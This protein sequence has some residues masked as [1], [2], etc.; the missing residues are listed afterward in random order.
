MTDER[1]RVNAPLVGGGRTKKLGPD[2][3]GQG[4]F[5]QLLTAYWRQPRSQWQWPCGPQPPCTWMTWPVALDAPE[6]GAAGMAWAPKVVNA[7]KAAIAANKANSLR[8]LF[9]PDVS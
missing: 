2:K 8:M 6:S 7:N 9:L 3:P 1:A 5:Q 4:R